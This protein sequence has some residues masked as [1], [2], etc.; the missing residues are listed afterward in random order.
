MSTEHAVTTDSAVFELDAALAELEEQGLTIR[1]HNKK[2]N[3][4]HIADGGLYSGYVA[5]GDEL[6]ELGRTGKLNMR[7]IIGLG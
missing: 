3:A 2:N 7:G 1:L 4:W 6:I 5:S